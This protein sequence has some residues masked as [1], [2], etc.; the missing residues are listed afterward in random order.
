MPREFDQFTITAE[1]IDRFK[2]TPDPRLKQI[3][4]AVVRHAHALVKETQLTEAE[5]S[6]AI[7]FLTRTGQ[8]CTDRRQEFILLSDTLGVSMLVDALNNG[9]PPGA[10]QSTVLRTLLRPGRPLGKERFGDRLGR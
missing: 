9:V 10:T 6:F 7:D 2:A 5:W 8:I 1:V 4:E 3:M